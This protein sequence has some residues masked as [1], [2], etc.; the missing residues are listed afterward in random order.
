[1]T[2]PAYDDWLRTSVEEMKNQQRETVD[3]IGNALEEIE[4]KKK[5]R[6][7]PHVTTVTRRDTTPTS[8]IDP[9]WNWTRPKT[10]VTNAGEWVTRPAN[11]RTR[12]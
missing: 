7:H 5:M 2:N 1:L 8:A 9:K 4:V 10:S 3:M 12:L 6:Y 11:A